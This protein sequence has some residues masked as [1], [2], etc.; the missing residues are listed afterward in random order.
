MKLDLVDPIEWKEIVDQIDSDFGDGATKRII[1]EL[2]PVS[3]DR[4][5][6]K[7]FYLIPAQW[8]RILDMDLSMFE[9][10]S[11]GIWLGE[12]VKD[13][14]RLSIAVINRLSEIT[15]S[16]VVVSDKGAQSFTYGRS[17]IR[18]SVLEVDY[19]LERGQRV[20]VLTQDGRCVGL[21][22]LSV[23]AHKINRLAKDRL[24]VKNVIDIG[25]YIRRLG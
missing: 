8:T 24:V 5:K 17:I 20:V 18:E 11:L 7:S 23:D 15:E 19:N 6:S 13:R 22:V 10:K 25:W 1:D 3:M 4:G 12:I 2:V 14:F 16:V 21:G 9:L